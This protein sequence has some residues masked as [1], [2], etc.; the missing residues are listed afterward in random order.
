VKPGITGLWQIESRT[1]AGPESIELYD[2][3]YL[4][5]WSFSKDIRILCRT[6]VCV[7]RGSGL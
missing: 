2:R 5:N 4:D 7:F 3:Q 1:D 6:V